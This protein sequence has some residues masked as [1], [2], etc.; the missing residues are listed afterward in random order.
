M[1]RAGAVGENGPVTNVAVAGR[2]RDGVRLLLRPSGPLPP[3]SLARPDLRRGRGA[4]PRPRRDPGRRRRRRRR[5]RSRIV[6]RSGRVPG[7]GAALRCPTPFLP[8]EQDQTGWTVA[9]A[10][11]GGAAAGVPPPVS[12]GGA[13]GRARH[14]PAG[15]RLRRRAAALLLRLRHRRLH[16]RRLQPVPD[17][18]AGEPAGGGVRSTRSSGSRRCPPS[19]TTPS[20]S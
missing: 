16:R 14:G 8:I 15:E 10:A 11:R 6:H 3:L 2:L 7:A 4:G 19:R 5:D 12:A 9:H 18:G 20:R 1:P 17:A 13:V